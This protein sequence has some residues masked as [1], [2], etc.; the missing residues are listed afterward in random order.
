M[1]EQK[2]YIFPLRFWSYIQKMIICYLL[3]ILELKN[4]EKIKTISN[5]RIL[6]IFTRWF[7]HNWYKKRTWFFNKINTIIV[8]NIIIIKK[9]Y[10]C[11]HSSYSLSADAE[12]RRT[13]RNRWV[14]AWC[15]LHKFLKVLTLYFMG[16][17][18]NSSKSYL[19]Y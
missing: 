13:V 15:Q 19:F 5:I 17:Y 14:K 18:L 16:K 12:E 7:E 3:C 11:L 6:C 4:R 1:L 10:I 8:F 2:G 9:F